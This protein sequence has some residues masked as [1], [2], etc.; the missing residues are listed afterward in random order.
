[1]FAG[2]HRIG[3]AMILQLVIPVS[4]QTV[5]SLLLVDLFHLSY[6]LRYSFVK[7]FGHVLHL[8]T[9]LPFI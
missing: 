7:Y 1:M 8:S 2:S 9:S 4:V 6:R 3:I 5:T